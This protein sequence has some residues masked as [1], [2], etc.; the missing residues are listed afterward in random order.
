MIADI[1][2]KSMNYAGSVIGNDW[3]ETS[4][5]NVD[6]LSLDIT[7]TLQTLK[8]NRADCRVIVFVENKENG[9]KLQQID[10]VNY[11]EEE[12]EEIVVENV[13]E[14]KY[15]PSIASIAE[16]AVDDDVKRD[17]KIELIRKKSVAM[18]DRKKQ[19]AALRM[20]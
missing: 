4:K 7:K 19:M 3:D 18:M 11:Q 16:H 9:N 15:K 1:D 13:K 20:K 2:T 5:S 17:E 10:T 14:F 12:K 6:N 8:I